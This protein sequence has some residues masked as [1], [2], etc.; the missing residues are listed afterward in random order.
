MLKEVIKMNK[1]EDCVSPHSHLIPPG[2][3]AAKK[4]GLILSILITVVI[5]LLEVVGGILTRSLALISDAGH[6]LTHFVDLGISLFAIIIAE[7]PPTSRKTFG[8]LRYEILAALFNSIFLFALTAYILYEAYERILNPQSIKGFEMFIVALLGLIANISSGIILF[9]V[10]HGDLNIRSAFLHMI[11]DT[12]SSVGVVIAAIIIHFTS[13]YIL[14]PIISV[15]IAVLIAVW[16]IKLF[17]EAVNILMQG[18]PKEIKIENVEESIQAI[19]GVEEIHDTHIWA[20][21][22]KMFVLTAHLI[23]N[24]MTVSDTEKL[25]KI[26][27]AKLFDEFEIFH[28]TIQFETQAKK[29]FKL[30]DK[31][32]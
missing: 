9:K 14:D 15:V 25:L 4:R 7:K 19:P 22:S 27:N 16:G 3:R 11:G 29:N 8:Y 23:V 26:I 21:S 20:I 2:D 31:K 24:D 5:M 12:V 1:S 13:F 17:N 30:D 10:S 18:I 32:V 6:M 28:T